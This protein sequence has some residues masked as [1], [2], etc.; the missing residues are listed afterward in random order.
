MTSWMTLF[1]PTAFPWG[2]SP[3]YYAFKHSKTHIAMPLGHGLV[4]NHHESEN[5][6]KERAD[7]S[8]DNFVFKV[9]GIVNVRS[10]T[11]HKRI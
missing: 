5:V 11:F 6:N 9:R 1:L 10:T 3:W 8:E 7:N 4:A 2:L